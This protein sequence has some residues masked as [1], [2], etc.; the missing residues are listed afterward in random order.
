MRGVSEEHHRFLK[1]DEP[2]LK[3]VHLAKALPSSHIPPGRSVNSEKQGIKCPIII[4]VITIEAMIILRIGQP[5][6][7]PRT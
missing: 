5:G 4:H 1:R 6:D 7:R 2:R 3:A